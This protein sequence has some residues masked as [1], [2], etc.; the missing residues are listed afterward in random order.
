MSDFER[1]SLSTLIDRA[2]SDIN[3]RL[4]GADSRLRRSVL[5]TLA[6]VVSG[7]LHGLYGYADHI[8]D[9]TLPDTATEALPRHAAIWGIAPKAATL[10]I[11][12]VHVTG[13]DGADV[14]AGT[15]LQRLDGTIYQTIADTELVGGA[16]DIAVTAVVAGTVGN[17]TAGT[18]LSFISPVAGVNSAAVVASGGLTGGNDAETN[19]QLRARLLQ[20]IRKRPQGGSAADFETWTLEV[21]G[22]TRVWVYRNWM[23]PGTVGI[24]FVMDGRENIFPTNDDLN[25]VLAYLTP[26]RP[27]CAD[28]YVFAPTPLPI[29]FVVRMVPDNANTRAGATAGLKEMVERDAEPGGAILLS[30]IHEALSTTP[31]ETDHTLYSPVADIDAPAAHLPVFQSVSFV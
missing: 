6:R 18:A 22:V 9:Q 27:I 21:P 28:L 26:R 16:R 31:G 30:R 8:A 23:G 14:P 11:G 4:T 12:P 15:E 19:E 29:E 20:L 17:A 5:G 13:T 1:P 7:G 25:T 10:A 3:S 24:T 2:E